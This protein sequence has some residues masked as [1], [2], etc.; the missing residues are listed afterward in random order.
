MFVSNGRFWLILSL[1]YWFIATVLGLGL[2][3]NKSGYL[4]GFNFQYLLHAHSHLAMLGW[5]YL[6]LVVGI[7]W[8]AYGE[9]GFRKT[10]FRRL[11]WM[12][13][14]A[15]LGMLF[16]FP[17]QGYGGFSIGFS[18]MHIILSYVFAIKLFQ[19][20]SKN[21]FHLNPLTRKFMAG[22]IVF[23]VLSS[24]GP[25][26]LAYIGAQGLKDTH[27]YEQ[28]IYFY[29]HFQY[30]GWFTFGLMGLWLHNTRIITDLR[31]KSGFWLLFLSTFPAFFISLMGYELPLFLEGLTWF[32]V[33]VQIIGIGLLWPELTSLIKLPLQKGNH[34]LRWLF[35]LAFVCLVGKF[36][37]Q[38][39]SLLPVLKPLAFET[40]PT[41]I[42]FLHW[43]MLGFTSFGLLY[44]LGRYQKLQ[45]F[46]MLKGGVWLSGVGFIIMELLFFLQ[47]G[48]IYWQ[49]QSITGFNLSM[50]IVT[51]MLVIGIGM[52]AISQVQS[53]FNKVSKG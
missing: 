14:I 15:I 47:G 31:A 28:A 41:V 23:M 51:A 18:T 8:L 5:V 42:G 1:F 17:F 24:L 11:L 52:I 43:V 7:I 45:P 38:G 33:V 35:Y 34:Y 39:I 20:W 40:R 10:F 16:T 36:I 48:S 22:G 12:T 9:S 25:W 27:W 19:G 6:A 26:A 32:S 50:A 37:M 49:S 29:L 30:N 53:G 4:S 21:T 13:Q 46:N 2:R 3:L 44:W